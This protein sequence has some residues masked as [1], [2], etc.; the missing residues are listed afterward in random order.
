MKKKLLTVSLVVFA[1]LPVFAG[2]RA[3]TGSAGAGGAMNITVTAQHWA[4]HPLPAEDSIIFKTIA[5][6]QNVKF[7]FDWRQ[8]SDYGAQVATLLASGKL[9]DLLDPSGYGIMALVKEGAIIQLDGYLEKYGKNI[10]AAIG[11]SNM[12]SWKSADGH[13]YNIPGI[14]MNLKG[15]QSMMI[16]KDWLDKLNLKEPSTWNEWLTV[17]RAFRDNDMNGDGDKS[18]EIPLCLEAGD[19]GERSMASLLCAF[20]IQASEDTQFCIYQGRYI[21]V[22]EHP[23]YLEFLEAVAGLYKEGILDKEFTTRTMNEQ[24]KIMDNGLCGSTMTW[25]ERASIS[26]TVNREAGN[27]NALWKCVAPIKGPYGDQSTQAR[28]WRCTPGLCITISAE[29]AGKVEGIIKFFDWFFSAKGIELYS[30]GVEGKTFDYVSG[31]PV[32][33]PAIIANRFT[34]MRAAGLDYEPFPGI[35]TVEAYMQCLTSGQS[36]NQLPDM[37]QSF[38]DGLFTVNNDYFYFQPDTLETDAYVSNRASLITTGVC[39]LRDRCIAGQIT[40]AQFKSQ[41]DALKGR[42]FQAIIDQGAAAYAAKRR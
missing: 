10:I 15:A 18:N 37:V 9:P 6:T 36:Y 1:L 22:Y 2:G 40:P 30:F 27:R 33:K 14:Y 32:L 17:W 8:A 5:E 19:N 29:K 25:A 26:T 28:D 39:V 21:P 4:P 35:W 24:F 31:K 3:A 12:A 13:I 20:G 23:R 42:G 16:R 41:Y 7:T 11:E 34:S 38:Y